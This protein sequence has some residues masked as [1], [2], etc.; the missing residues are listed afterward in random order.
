METIKELLGSTEL[1]GSP[2]LSMGVVVRAGRKLFYLTRKCCLE[3][4]PVA[5]RNEVWVKISG[6][7][8][9]RRYDQDWFCFKCS[10]CGWRPSGAYAGWDQAFY[11][12]EGM[13][14]SDMASCHVAALKM[15]ACFG[16]ILSAMEG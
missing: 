11:L 9:R 16:A 6:Q 2:C 13:Y 5:H 8:K 12:W 3:S 1:V 10:K 7:R 4:M 15:G 14:S